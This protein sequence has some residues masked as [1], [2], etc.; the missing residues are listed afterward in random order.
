MSRTVFTT[1]EW[2]EKFNR[3]VKLA[4]KTFPVAESHF[5][6]SFKCNVDDSFP[7]T[8]TIYAISPKGRSWHVWARSSAG[9]SE[10][11]FHKDVLNY[12]GAEAPAKLSGGQEYK[13]MD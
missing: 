1:E 9:G 4:Y 6:K 2:Q 12:L 13:K 11:K 3:D 10:F 8:F 5:G 7:Q